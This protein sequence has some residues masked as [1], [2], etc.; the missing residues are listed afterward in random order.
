LGGKPGI[1]SAR[2][3]ETDGAR[4]SDAER[5]ALLIAEMAGESNRRARFVCAMVL[6]LDENRFYIVQETLEGEII[7]EERGAGGFGYDPILF[8]PAAGR[9]VA[10]LSD[11]EKNAMSHRG[12]AGR[13][14]GNMLDAAA[15]A[16]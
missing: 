16:L 13:I 5:N 12:K 9:A 8:L 1:F 6:L 4:L 14:I 3:G 15:S 7:R 10:E 11:A 2:Y